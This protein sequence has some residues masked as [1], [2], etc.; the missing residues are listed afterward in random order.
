[1]FDFKLHQKNNKINKT[2]NKQTKAEKVYGT[3]RISEDF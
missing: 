1:M 3:P 2:K